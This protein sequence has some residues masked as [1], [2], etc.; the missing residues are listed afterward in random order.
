MF[1]RRRRSDDPDDPAIATT[2]GTSEDMSEDVSAQAGASRPGG[3]FDVSEVDL[4]DP[5][6]RRVDLGGLLVR[7]IEGMQ[8]QLQV[9]ERSGAA[10]GVTIVLGDAAVQLVAVAAPRS[11]G[12]WEQ[13]RLQL[14]ADAQRRGGTVQ[15]ARGPFGTEVRRVLPVTTPDGKSGVQPS[16][17]A[18]IDGP[19]W[20]LRATFLGKATTD[21]QVFGRLVQVVRDT[22][23]VRGDRPMAPGDVIP[24]K[25]PV[26][27]ES[28]SDSADQAP[29]T[30]G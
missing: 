23:V 6:Q 20:M 25:A 22:V 27:D 17:V 28:S 24:L 26:R 3:P 18:G 15:E 1:R 30:D 9:D 7:G 21:V 16:R 8:L 29:A 12:M 2:A 5:V 14:A 4:T 10:T 11:S 13:I 19:R